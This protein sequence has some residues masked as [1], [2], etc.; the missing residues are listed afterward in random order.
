[1]KE[2]LLDHFHG[3]KTINLYK[4]KFNKSTR[5]PGEKIIDYAH[6]LQEIF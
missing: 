1:M 5:K 6:Y 2:F 4:K 3:D